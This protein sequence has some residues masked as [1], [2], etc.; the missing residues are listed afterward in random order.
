MK[1]IAIL[2]SSVGISCDLIPV[3]NY[4]DK[5]DYHAFVEE[6]YLDIKDNW[7]RHKLIPFSS[8][9]T[10]KNRRDAKIYKILPHLFLPGYEYYFWIDSTH[11]LEVD[12][13][14]VIDTYLNTS[15]IAVFK[16][17]YRD[18]VYEESE[19]I[20][21]ANYDHHN[22][23]DDQIAFYMDMNYPEHYGLYELP[24]RVQRNTELM[25]R[26]GLMWWEQIC[27]FSSRDQM[28]FPFVC[29]QLNISPSI[30]PGYA[31][32][33]RGNDIIP[34]VINSNHRRTFHV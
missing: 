18:C 28:S 27:M 29:H 1:K 25:Q 34:Q 32:N 3:E 12:P 7:N 17:Q 16:H 10:Y 20:K 13:E 6:Q 2:T 9:I 8:D 23:L 19:H 4:L 31:N 30:L 21:E 15:D 5:V 33:I 26:M 14:Q 24:A 22:L 11:C